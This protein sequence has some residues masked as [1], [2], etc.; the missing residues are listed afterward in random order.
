MQTQL[1][2]LARFSEEGR[3][4]RLTDDSEWKAVCKIRL[5][6][7][8]PRTQCAR[9]V[10]VRKSRPVSQFCHT[11]FTTDII[12]YIQVTHTHTYGLWEKKVLFFKKKKNSG[13]FPPLL[14]LACFA[15]LQCCSIFQRECFKEANRYGRRNLLVPGFMKPMQILRANPL[16]PIPFPLPSCVSSCLYLAGIAGFPPF[17]ISTSPVKGT[18]MWWPLCCL[19]S[20]LLCL[21]LPMLNL[22]SLILWL[23]FLK[24]VCDLCV[25][26]AA[27]VMEQEKKENVPDTGIAI[28]RFFFCC[29]M[30]SQQLEN[31]SYLRAVLWKPSRITLTQ[32][33]FKFDIQTSLCFK[34]LKEKNRL[35]SLS[36]AIR[37]MVWM[38]AD[39]SINFT[40]TYNNLKQFWI[41]K[42]AL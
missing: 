1:S 18:K 37:T 21:Y 4:Q 19:L 36:C 14:S 17:L 16:P 29:C 26:S 23:L 6:S 22:F 35:W 15:S 32:Y 38:L 8:F 40:A 3:G 33:Y 31:D 12:C 11:L 24:S 42:Y 2:F 5:Y 30:L 10:R 25:L 39:A 27:F 13:L 28:L 7:L 9:S 41:G 20:R 34:K